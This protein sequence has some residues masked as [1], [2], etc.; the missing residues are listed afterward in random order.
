MQRPFPAYDGDE[1]YIFVS[2]APS[3]SRVVY[4]ELARLREAGFRIWYDEVPAG[5]ITHPSDL[6]R[7]QRHLKTDS[8]VAPRRVSA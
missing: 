2:Y 3:D 1:P 8:A 5:P 6:L 7:S 4:G